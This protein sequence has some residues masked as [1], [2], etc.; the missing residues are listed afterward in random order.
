MTTQQPVLWKVNE[1][2]APDATFATA[3]ATAIPGV[4]HD[5][6]VPAPLRAEAYGASLQSDGR[7]VTMGYGPTSAAG[8]TDSDWLSF[9][10]G[11]DGV[12]DTTYG[13]AG[14]THYLDF[15]MAADNARTVI[16]LSDD[17]V[18]GAGGGRVQPV[19]MPEVDAALAL[20]GADGVPDTTFG[21]GATA[22]MPFRTYDVGG[23]DFL[24]GGALSDDGRVAA[25]VGIAGAETA[26][27][28][29]DSLLLYFVPSP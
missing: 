29:D 18:L 11:A 20:Y 14:G 26:T 5:F 28:D 10:F 19:G 3:D 16:V 25:F 24:W 2:G 7:L 23:T 27:D 6:A 22:G 1:D 21:T 9:R 12:R 13:T 15:G 4:W 17:R 8:R